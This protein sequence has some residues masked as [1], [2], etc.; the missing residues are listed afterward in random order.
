M[1]RIH[2]GIIRGLSISHRGVI[3]GVR[4]RECGILDSFELLNASVIDENVFKKL[5]TRAGREP[6]AD[7]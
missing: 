3:S 6:V 7:F 2:R 1:R 5:A 4:A